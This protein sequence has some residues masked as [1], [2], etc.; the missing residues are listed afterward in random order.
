MTVEERKL[1]VLSINDDK[2]K[3]K[4]IVDSLAGS[5]VIYQIIQ[6]DNLDL[7]RDILETS[8]VD[9]V[10]TEVE[11]NG[12]KIFDLMESHQHLPWIVLSAMKDHKVLRQAFNSGAADYIVRNGRNTNL[13]GLDKIILG[14]L[15]RWNSRMDNH[16]SDQKSSP[17][18]HSTASEL[19]LVNLR[20]AEESHQRLVALEELRESKELYR[21]FFQHS[22]DAVWITSI[23]GHWID[24][25]GSALALFGY[26][27]KEDIWTDT[28]L[29]FFWDTDQGQDYSRKLEVEGFVNDHPIKFRKKDGSI[30]NALI[31]AI[32]YEIGGNVIGYQGL[33][34]DLTDELKSKDE[35]L[36]LHKNQAILDS[37]ARDMGNM[38][39]LNDIYS[40]ISNH[41]KEMIVPDWI[42]ILKFD[43]LQDNF[44]IEFEWGMNSPRG[45][46]TIELEYFENNYQALIH[47]TAKTKQTTIADLDDSLYQDQKKSADTSKNLIEAEGSGWDQDHDFPT[48]ILT[49]I[50]IN[51]QVIGIIHVVFKSNKPPG[52]ED[53]SFL[54]RAANIVAICLKKAYLLEYSEAH[55][56]KLSSLQRVQQIILENLS[57]PTTMDMMVDQVVTELGVDA[58]NILYLHPGLKTLRLISQKGFKQKIFR[59]NGLEIGEG[60]AGRAVET[61]SI[62]H[63]RDLSNSPDQ[64]NRSLEFSTEKFVTYFGVPLLVKNRL[65]G[66][67]EIFNRSVLE[68][69]AYWLDLLKLIS[70]LVAI[71]IDLQNL[72]NDLEK[73][74]KKIAE[75]FDGVIMGWATALELRG[76]EARGH[77]SRV[78]DLTYRLAKRMGFEGKN[79]EDIRRGALLHDIGKMGIA[80][81]VLL[82]GSILNAEEMRLIGHHP[83]DAFELL[84]SV[85]GLKGSLDIPLYHHERWDGEGYP[86]GIEGEEIPLSARIFAVVDV[87]DALQTDRPYRKAYSRTEALSHLR[88]QSGKHFDPEVLRAFLEMMEEDQPEE[89]TELPAKDQKKKSE[90]SASV[91]LRSKT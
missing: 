45:S 30:I 44:K 48:L 81:E 41:I 80:D 35:N 13:P 87:W 49:P 5:N 2:T 50:L 58:V 34:R 59:D 54:K 23:D 9:L 8:D 37:L 18:N 14:V 29:N 57:L 46:K 39:E 31:T 75:A 85:E 43:E 83:V 38:L 89:P 6:Y 19:H 47:E 1:T 24:M 36:K 74:R 11:L 73:S 32:P 51:D 67:L 70:G 84:K 62:I 26:E 20:L 76:I 64:I 27:D 65:V 72:T 61:K 12:K 91:A 78:E 16:T 28:M 88:E 90:I 7:A 60:L 10:I 66:V 4:Q 53:L 25:N 77:A 82:K 71:A 55:V 22:R 52:S 42:R 40:S 56:K 17:E 15:E 86:Y 63:V 68:P 79:L 21:R 33:I 69:E 3:Q